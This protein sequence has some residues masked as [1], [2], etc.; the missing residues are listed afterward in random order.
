MISQYDNQ[1]QAGPD[2][3]FPYLNEN[4][5]MKFPDPADSRN[6]S[7][8]AWGGN[9]SPG[10]LLSAYEQGLFPWYNDDEPI[11]WH[12][13][14]PRFV[15]FPEKL[16]ISKSMKKILCR[17]DFEISFDRD[18]EAVIRSCSQVYR[19]GQGGTWINSDIMEEWGS[20]RG[21]V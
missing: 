1:M 5:R 8:I 2:P 15:I 20:F 16:H 7:I 19:P 9:L 10:M 17:N 4:Q 3:S 6:D 11:L 12:S 14:D 13:P 21:V 18:F